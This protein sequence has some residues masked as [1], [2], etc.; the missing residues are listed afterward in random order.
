[1]SLAFNAFG[2]KKKLLLIDH[3]CSSTKAKCDYLYGSIKN[4]HIRK[5][6]T[7]NGEPRVIAGNAEEEDIIC[8]FSC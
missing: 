6:L 7:K 3:L 2:L 8:V 1:M 4:D 5:N